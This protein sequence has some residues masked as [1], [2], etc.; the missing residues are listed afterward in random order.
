M[1]SRKRRKGQRSLIQLP[2]QLSAGLALA[3]FIGMR[4]LLPAFMPASGPLAAIGPMFAQMA[5]LPFCAFGALAMLAALRSRLQR[6]SDSPSRPG[7]GEPAPA[8]AD[9]PPAAPTRWSLDALRSLEWKR[10]EL[11]CARY[12][13]AVGFRSATL[14]AGADGGIDVKLFRVDPS[15]PLAIVQCKAW[16]TRQVGVKEIRELLGVM[17]HEKVT[18]GIFVTTGS[19]SAEALAF[20]AANPIQL[21][22]GPAFLRKILDLPSEQQ[23]SLLA[24]AFDG[25]FH[26]PSCASCGV[27]MVARDSRRGA[28][29]GCTH[30]PRC[31]T[32]LPMRQAA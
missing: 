28:F 14:A 23:A 5:W 3:S 17:V 21:L 4:W 32:T 19:Y 29:W 24:F 12:Y 31:K 30:Y 9:C 22:D 27:K 7:T 8:L 20:G 11:L 1:G 6:R 10:F 25:D 13:E 16:N 15:Q 26:T 2:W 18:R